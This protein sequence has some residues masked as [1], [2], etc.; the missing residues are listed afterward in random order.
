MNWNGLGN[1]RRNKKL[2]QDV[3]KERQAEGAGPSCQQWGWQHVHTCE[4]GLTVPS[5]SQAGPTTCMGP[6][7]SRTP[8]FEHGL[9]LGSHPTC[10]SELK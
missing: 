8:L 2:E 9:D 10:K 3:G 6:G 7:A 5:T 1:C 4:Q